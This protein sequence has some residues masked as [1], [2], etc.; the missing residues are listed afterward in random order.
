MRLAPPLTYANIVIKLTS[1]RLGSTYIQ[2]L[3]GQILVQNMRQ[4]GIVV[5][6]PQDSAKVIAAVPPSCEKASRPPDIL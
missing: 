6:I 4:S 3:C 2:C 5:G 1:S